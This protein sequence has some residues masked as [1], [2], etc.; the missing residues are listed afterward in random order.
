MTD[1]HHN[2]VPE[3]VAGRSRPLSRIKGMML[4]LSRRLQSSIWIFLDST[5]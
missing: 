1:L 3:A 4:L 2:S 5:T